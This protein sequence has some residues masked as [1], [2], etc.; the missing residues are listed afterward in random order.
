MQLSG[1]HLF[2]SFLTQENRWLHL[3]ICPCFLYGILQLL[4]ILYN[5]QALHQSLR[6][7]MSPA[8]VVILQFVIHQI[9]WSISIFFGSFFKPDCPGKMG[10]NIHFIKFLPL[11]SFLLY[12]QAKK[13]KNKKSNSSHDRLTCRSIEIKGLRTVI[14]TEISI[15]D[16]NRIF[17]SSLVVIIK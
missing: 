11:T 4:R 10:V 9:C 5:V 3:E 14:L 15:S 7:E 2:P 1:K 12:N 6:T 8:S 17:S 16:M 13:T